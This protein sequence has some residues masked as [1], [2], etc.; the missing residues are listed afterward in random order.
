MDFSLLGCFCTMALQRASLENARPGVS[1]SASS[2]CLLPSIGLTTSPRPVGAED[3]QRPPST[4]SIYSYTRSCEPHLTDDQLVLLGEI[5]F[6][7]L[8]VKRS[9]SLAYTS[10]D[11]VVGTVAGAEPATEV[12]SL[13][14]W[15]TTQMCADACYV[16]VQVVL[17]ARVLSLIASPEAFWGSADG[18]SIVG[19]AFCLPSMTSHSGFFTR[20]SSCWG[21]RRDETL[22]LFASA[23]S[24]SVRCRMKTGLPR[25]LMMTC[26]MAPHVSDIRTS[27]SRHRAGY[28]HVLALWD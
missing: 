22:T 18:G 2:V 5:V 10:G 16:S 13:A 25:H 12:T 21:S 8:E 3:W 9:R 28:T 23:I 15:H 26:M 6:G 24:A 7:D 27:T 20:S 4:V 17:S 11:I 1:L 19:R 14:D